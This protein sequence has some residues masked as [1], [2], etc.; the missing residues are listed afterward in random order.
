M[1]RIFNT[2]L[3]SLL[4]TL[5]IGA[6]S[7]LGIGNTSLDALSNSHLT[8]RV[9]P[10]KYL[11]SVDRMMKFSPDGSRIVVRS[12]TGIELIAT[13]SLEHITAFK[14]PSSDI[15]WV[16]YL[17]TNLI[18]FDNNSSGGLLFPDL[19]RQSLPDGTKFIRNDG[20]FAVTSSGDRSKDRNFEGVVETKTDR[21][22]CRLRVEWPY[23]TMIGKYYAA[24][25]NRGR[26]VE[27]CELA[28]GQITFLQDPND[29]DR[30]KVVLDS[31]GQFLLV[32]SDRTSLFGVMHGRTD[33]KL[34]RLPVAPERVLSR[35]GEVKQAIEAKPVKTWDW[36]ISM[37]AAFSPDGKWLMITSA[38]KSEL[39]RT[40]S[41]DQGL[42]LQIRSPFATAIFSRDSKWVVTEDTTSIYVA[43]LDANPTFTKLV[44][45]DNP[46]DFNV[47]DIAPNGSALLGTTR[48]TLKDA[49]KR[50]LWRIETGKN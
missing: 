35:N 22:V 29:A 50:V 19:T 17:D 1:R 5:L 36:H 40:D 30:S 16:S 10:E 15:S 42:T 26:T 34:Y 24:S 46:E 23:S 7:S 8:E 27:L 38:D 41:L 48:R 37:R 4:S 3:I 6:C 32:I 25:G 47:S 18:A 45:P 28:T 49:P 21:H 31:T 9:L 20:R 2:T 13:H 33:A 12:L 43:K 11:G 44:V 14:T 39:V